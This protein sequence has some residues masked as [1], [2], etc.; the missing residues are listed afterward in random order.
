MLDRRR[1][2]GPLDIGQFSKRYRPSARR[3]DRDLR[4]AFGVLTPLGRKLHHQRIARPPLVDDAGLDAPHGRHRPHHFDSIDGMPGQLVGPGIDLHSGHVGLPVGP[5][6]GRSA[7]APKHSLDLFAEIPQRVEVV[8]VDQHRDV[9][10]HARHEFVDPHLDRL[11]EA[12]VGARHRGGQRCRHP[13]HELIPCHAG[14]PLGMRLEHHPDVGLLHAHDVV[15]DL[16]PAGLAEDRLHLGKL[17]ERLFDPGRDRHRILQRGTGQTVDLDEQIAFVEPRHELGAKVECHR[18]AGHHKA[19]GQKRHD[20]RMVDGDF[21]ER[22]VEAV[23]QPHQQRL[24]LLLAGQHRGRQHRHERERDDQRPGQR[25]EHRQ[26]H[27]P[28][29]LPFGSLEKE[30]RQVDDGDDQL[31]EHRRT[32][33]LD[34]RVADDRQLRFCR[35]RQAEPPHAVFHHDHGAVDHEPEIDRPEAHQARRD[36]GGPHEIGGKQHRQRNR[37]RHDQA[38]ADISQQE[39]QH[40][41]HE[42]AA[43]GQIVEHGVERPGD[44]V[45]PVVENVEFDPGGQGRADRV[46]PLLRRRHH[47]PAVFTADHHHHSCDH[48]AAAVPRGGALPHQGRDQDIADV[49]DEHGDA[50]GRTPYDHLLD[51]VG[52]RQQGLPADEPLLAV[53]DDVAAAGADVVAFE[54]RQ[55]LAQRDSLRRHPVGVDAD[56]VALRVAAMAVDIGHARHLPHRRCDLPFQQAAEI[57]QVLPRP[58]HLELENLAERRAQGSELRVGAGQRD[59]ALCLRQPL[60]DE[61]PGQ[62]DIGALTKDDRHQRDAEP[63]DAADLLHVGQSADSQFNGIGDRPLHF[64]RRERASLRHDLHL[65]VD[66]IGDR[67]HGHVCGGVEAAQR[68]QHEHRDHERPV[69]KRPLD[70][71]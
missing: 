31:T 25:E 47:P 50:P 64:Q 11:A 5:H 2:L 28:K 37:Q 67:I 12:E 10:L 58:L 32:A 57:H 38:G 9:G 71:T 34:G 45:R 16:W 61:L 44:Q 24:V 40:A 33:D 52:V 46:Q 7:D 6:V 65:D 14:R 60:S 55:H 56:L 27:R 63:R 35:C 18:N 3:P 54:G 69:A 62:E 48:L 20:H 15:G 21:R 26:G 23:K 8:A 17:A 29:Q 39:E 22:M 1:A 66:E 70:E 36:A 30:D 59:P 68:H 43:F 19:R 53:F 41:D 42:Q 49:A 4:Q 51:G 13:L